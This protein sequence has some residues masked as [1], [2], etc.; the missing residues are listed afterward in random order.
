MVNMK[1]LIVIVL[2]VGLISCSSYEKTNSLT[3]TNYPNGGVKTYLSQKSKKSKEFNL[4]EHYQRWDKVY[5]EYSNSGSKLTHS[6]QRYKHA[7]YGRP[8][9]EIK[10]VYKEYHDNGKLRLLQK[11]KCDCKTSV[12]KEYNEKGKLIQVKRSHQKRIK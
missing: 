3:T 11:D 6:E 5:I 10:Y 12:I 4:H 1:Y 7:T 2:L 8:C 9:H